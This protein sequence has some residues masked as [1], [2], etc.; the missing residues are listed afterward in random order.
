MGQLIKEMV[1][2]IHKKNRYGTEAFNFDT[3]NIV[4][5]GGG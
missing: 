4:K 5:I 3:L 2:L 1:H